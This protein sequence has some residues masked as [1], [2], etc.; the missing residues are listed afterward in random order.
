VP[1]GFVIGWGLLL[2]FGIMDFVGNTSFESL[3]LLEYLLLPNPY[4]RAIQLPSNRI[5][6]VP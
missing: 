2:G 5:F 3:G 6:Y 1:V 4:R